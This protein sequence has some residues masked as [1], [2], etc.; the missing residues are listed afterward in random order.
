MRR[1]LHR[2][3]V[4]KPNAAVH[5]FTHTGHNSGRCGKPKRARTSNHQ[6][7]NGV[8]NGSVELL[9]KQPSKHESKCRNGKYCRNKNTGNFIGKARNGRLCTLRFGKRTHHIT[10]QGL[11]AELIRTISQTAFRHHRTGQHGTLRL[12]HLRCRFAG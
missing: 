2:R 12:L 10:E 11:R 5:C 1:L 8:H 4:F 3:C 7:R 9:R 6:Y